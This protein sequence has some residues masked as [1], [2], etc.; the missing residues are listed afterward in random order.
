MN[1]E[2]APVMDGE[3]DPVCGMMVD[4]ETSVSSEHN[5]HTYY[6][7]CGHCKTKFE[8]DP[9][10]YLDGTAQQQ[11][12]EHVPGQAYTCPMH[13]DVLEDL[14]GDCPDCGMALEPL[15]PAAAETQVEYTCPM[16]PEVVQPE[17]GDCPQ[18]GMA[19]EPRVLTVE[20]EENPELVDMRR[21]LKICAVLT[22]PLLIVAM[23]D[24]IPALGIR[25]LLGAGTVGWLQAALA[26]PVVLW[27][28]WPFFVRA[29]RSYR[30]MRLN[31]WSL[32]G[33][34]VAA[35]YL[36]SL[37]ALLFPDLLPDN[38]K[39]D[40]HVPLYFE[41]AAIIITLV[42]IGQVL[43]LRARSQTT[44]AIRSLLNLTP[45]VAHRLDA[46]GRETDVAL[47][48]VH[49]GDRL[50]VRSGEKVPVDGAILDGHSS[51]DESMITGES[52][53][54][55]KTT[56]DA[57]TG[58][59]L[60]QTG[61]FIMEATRVGSDT[62]LARITQ[63]VSEASRSRA[64]IQRLADRVAAWFVP[65][66][67]SVALFAFVAWA[68]WGPE[69]VLINALVVAISV[70]II[71][72]PCALGL[73]TPMSIMVGMGQGAKSG[74][75]IK[76]AVV[77]ET[78][79]TVDTLVVDKTGTLTE[80][81]PGVMAVEPVE[82]LTEDELLL[83][84]ASLE[85]GSEHPLARAVVQAVADRGLDL[86]PVMLFDTVVGRGVRGLVEGQMVLVGNRRLLEEAGLDVSPLEPRA[87]ALRQEGQT[88]LFVAI[89]QQVAGLLGVADPVKKSTAAAL[90][91]L[92]EE[93][94][95]ILML[96]GDN[97]TTARAVAGQLGLTEVHAGVLPEDKHEIVKQ[98]QAE[99]RK[100]VMAGDGINDAPA[101]AQADVGIAMGTGTDI[102]MESGNVTLVKGN[103]NGIVRARTLSRATMRNI[104]QNLFFAF[105]Y[106]ALGV[107]IAAGL[108]YPFFGIL[109]SPVLAGAAM[110]FSSVSV[111]ANALRLR[112]L[113][114]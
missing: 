46:N 56:G 22:V 78:L 113:K 107:P 31:M 38:L 13:P 4:P 49:V 45:D 42:L 18:C 93:G 101:L 16:H 32:I 15:A 6:F 60:N 9:N 33:V 105:V 97:E 89:N 28:G 37:A 80:G 10:G 73:A 68:I 84:V 5:G 71:A 30:T 102:A 61:S 57:V 65:M 63:R 74:V 48:H 66:V 44:D 7:C 24:M 85:Q 90:N 19:L 23:G 81:K 82:G 20:L 27:G 106:N 94:M 35:A 29:V 12:I 104:R 34:G 79:E 114:L 70:L 25:S 2:H 72:C 3:R 100:V 88:I 64:P 75:L 50:R 76:D 67:I 98:L 43:E 110:S 91:A 77:L 59:T 51:L 41:A 40:G 103:L 83:W 108:L 1:H 11:V 62:L 87:E 95:R 47:V 69:P 55:D 99:G 21:R 52:L 54:V 86:R 58:G 111:I 39:M 109:L 26:T 92:R 53:P 112:R 36:F 17:P 8:V 14:P 96:T